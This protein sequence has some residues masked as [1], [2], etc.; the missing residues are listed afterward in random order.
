MN[1]GHAEV[2][3]LDHSLCLIQIRKN[4]VHY[5]R[6]SR[7]KLLMQCGGLK[8]MN[9]RSLWEISMHTLGTMLGY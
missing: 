3:L 5:S 7:K 8:L 4:Q 2:E 6:T 9:P 1:V